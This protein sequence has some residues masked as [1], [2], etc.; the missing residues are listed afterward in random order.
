MEDT[1]E[2]GLLTLDEENALARYME[3]FSITPEQLNRNGAQSPGRGHSGRSRGRRP[4][5]AEH[6]GKNPVQPD[7]VGDPSL[8]HGGRRLPGGRYP[9]GKKRIVPRVQLQDRPGRLL[10]SKRI[11]VR[12]VPRRVRDHAGRPDGQ[13]AEI[14]GRQLEF[15][16]K[17]RRPST[18]LT[19]PS[20]GPIQLKP[21][22]KTHPTRHP[23]R[24]FRPHGP[25]STP[26]GSPKLLRV[27]P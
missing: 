24:A 10:P 23:G 12:A 5:E 1:L 22:P 9:E 15:T 11:P 27:S 25:H 18:S 19:D 20:T 17:N 26:S 3:H 14:L 2:D 4:P 21:A 7:E 13:A 16:T 8:G 6:P